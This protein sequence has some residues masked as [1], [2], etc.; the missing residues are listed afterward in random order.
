MIRLSLL[1]SLDLRAS[2]G[3]QILSV[4]AQ[5]K[6]VAL[7]AYLAANRDFVR[8]RSTRFEEA[9]ALAH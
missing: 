1:G 8:S 5:P 2:D 9:S 6:R 7:L 3:R 4:L